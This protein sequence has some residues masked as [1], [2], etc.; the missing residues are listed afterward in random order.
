MTGSLYALWPF[1]K[2]VFMAQQYVKQAGQVVC[3][4]NVTIQTNINML[5]TKDD[6]VIA[7]F[8]F[9]VLGGIIMMLFVRKEAAVSAVDK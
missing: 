9:F 5:P 4:E 3:L 8:V 7:A 1:K 2:T 6:P